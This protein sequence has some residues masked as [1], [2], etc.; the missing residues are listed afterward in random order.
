MFF[1]RQEDYVGSV[2]HQYIINTVPWLGLRQRQNK[3]TSDKGKGRSKYDNKQKN[4][5][6]KEKQI[7]FTK[8]SK[9]R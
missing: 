5:V 2:F 3:K 9:R 7:M 8:R 6:S 1:E 4:G